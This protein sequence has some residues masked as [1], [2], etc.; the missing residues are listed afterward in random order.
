MKKK[1][2]ELI[3]RT[4]DGDQSAFTTLVEKYQ[5]GV[6]ALVWQKI[7]DFHIAQDITQDAFLRAYQ[8]LGT[9]KNHKLFSGWLYV[10]ATR[11]CYEW[12]RKK[13][14][15]IQSIDTIDNTE[16]DQMAYE[17]YMEDERE[18]DVKE[19][20]REL[21]R[22]LLKK[23]P[24]SERTVMTLHYLGEMK[25][26]TI[27]EFLGVSPNTV[28]S[29]LSRA[30]NRLKKEEYMIQENLS[31]FILPLNM[32]EEI[33][34]RI[35]EIQPALPPITKPLLPWALSATS[36]I[37]VFMLVGIGFQHHFQFQEPY[38]LD[39]AS[40]TMIEIVDTQF[41]LAAQP[42]KEEST[43]LTQVRQSN[44]IGT[45]NGINQQQNTP[46]LETSEVVTVEQSKTKLKWK[47]T[48]G[49]SGGN[50]RT[51]FAT[52]DGILF[53]GTGN[54]GIYRSTDHG[55]SW[56]PANTGLANIHEGNKVYLSAFAQKGNTI[57]AGVRSPATLYASTDSGKTWYQVATHLQ[58][59]IITG[60]V[61]IDNRIYISTKP[62]GRGMGGVWYTDDEKSWMPMNV[63][64][65]ENR[66]NKFANIGT[67]LVVGTRNGAYRKKASEDSWIS[68][69]SGLTSQL[70]T[71]SNI[72][73]ESIAV[74]DN[75]LY[76]SVF[77]GNDRED[78]GLF[79]SDDEG[80]S[81]TRIAARVMKRSVDTLTVF[82]SMLF[83]RTDGKVYR[84]DDKG[85][86]WK[87]ISNGLIDKIGSAVVAISA[88]TVFVNTSH[89]KPWIRIN[90]SENSSTIVFMPTFEGSI[91]RTTDGGN[92][93]VEAN[94][95]I[96]E[97]SVVDLE[98]VG[99]RIYALTD[100]R[101]FYSTNRGETWERIKFSQNLSEFRFAKISALNGK[102]YVGA[103]RYTQQEGGLVGG[104]FQ[105]DERNNSLIEVKTD[106]DMYGIECMHI[107]GT[108]FYVGTIHEQGVFLSNEGWDSWLNLGLNDQDIDI[109]EITVSDSN[110]YAKTQHGKI[111]Y[112]KE[113][114]G[115]WELYKDNNAHRLF[116]QSTKIDN[117]HY[118]LSK[119]EGLI[120]SV[121]GGNSWVH[122]NAGIEYDDHIS[123]ASVEIDGP[124]FYIC[125]K[126]NEI[127]KWSH[128]DETWEKLG[129][130]SQPVQSL[131]VMDGVLYAGTK[132]GVFRVEQDINTI[133]IKQ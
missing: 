42:V 66:I 91:L 55:D 12:Q 25:C 84:S 78:N 39:A 32:T 89:Q 92:S 122:L 3:Q 44:V 69:N 34:T 76:I 13:R 87:L 111:H 80:N 15:P 20:Q 59:T 110:V 75:L 128:N 65:K 72:H 124:D 67:T 79:R 132:S 115:T 108:T 22:N 120:Q 2:V 127:Y 19:K 33:M 126:E 9:L 35:S 57:Y 95:G 45:N 100:N 11:L 38:S 63:G 24:E 17:Q 31:S 4:L 106:R 30:R 16:V 82:E 40:E 112:L 23:L 131:A 121:D 130:L 102:L 46:L 21:I 51:L 70:L 47:Q 5:K 36:A 129:S 88:D 104:I 99:N 117:K 41:V 86:S 60:I 103:A 62:N 48:N 118:I 94:T 116:A 107:V 6:H 29:R 68:I 83:A 74:M 8:K 93:W 119:R 98:V 105:F 26:E 1:D 114:Q 10:I 53:A 7:G 18:K 58:D 52:S 14:L 28:R 50:I 54:Q 133:T 97:T 43:E 90:E 27:S 109:T 125:T 49:P 123:L 85:D 71:P 113:H 101:I 64:L 61:I 77:M 73:V 37:L 96:M 56:S 81:W